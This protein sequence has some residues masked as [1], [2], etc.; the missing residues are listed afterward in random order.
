MNKE[1]INWITKGRQEDA[2]ALGDWYYINGHTAS[3]LN[4]YLRGAEFEDNEKT[5]YCLCRI[6]MCLSS[7]GNRTFYAKTAYMHA[8]NLYPNR[9]E[10]YHLL[11]K[12]F[13]WTKEWQES[14]VWADLGINTG[15]TE[16]MSGLEWLGI[17]GLRFQK[18][19]AGWWLNRI[20]ESLEIMLNLERNSVLPL[21]HQNAI[22]RNIKTMTDS[23]VYVDFYKGSQYE[24]IRNPFPGLES[25]KANYS[26][27]Y[28][29]LFVLTALN[30]KKGGKYL[31]VGSADPFYYSNTAL[32]ETEFHWDGI[33]LEIKPEEVRK[34][35]EKRKNKCI[36]GDALKTNWEA[37]MDEANWG[38]DWDYLQ[39][40]C[41][42]PIN[43]YLILL[44]IPFHKYR[45]RTIT[46]EHDHYTDE[47]S[48]IREKSRR[49]LT[50]MGYELIVSN[51]SPDE[52][53][54]FEDWWVHPELVDREIIDKIRMNGEIIH[55]KKWIFNDM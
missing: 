46:F 22:K 48:G 39:L 8:I 25:V 20:D 43:T 18:A 47:S 12:T 55:A 16:G 37:V 45:F 10:A 17:D 51:V 44:D 7:Q 49:Y 32:L 28:Q 21:E 50:A 31:E 42:P 13:E 54:P 1:L 38:R 40:D 35:R 3:A 27:C 24:K 4:W 9:G 34:F 26:Q 53:S 41:E 36:E 14:Y 19:V 2:I 6:G 15:A 5:Y 33:S 11:S 52:K 30:G 23:W 29:D